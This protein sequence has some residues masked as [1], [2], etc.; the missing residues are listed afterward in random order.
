MGGEERVGKM[1]QL[2]STQTPLFIEQ[3]VRLVLH[4]THLRTSC[5][6]KWKVYMNSYRGG[7]ECYH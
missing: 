2:I 1:S 5:Q 7:I 6:D 3:P 4:K